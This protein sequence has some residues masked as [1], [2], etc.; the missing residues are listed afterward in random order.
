MSQ[1]TSSAYHLKPQ[2]S[3]EAEP[4]VAGEKTCGFCIFL[5]NKLHEVLE[6]NQTEIDIEQYLLGACA[7]LPT[8]DEANKVGFYTLKKFDQY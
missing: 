3:L 4:N 1:W 5:F 6:Q 7:L 2:D 8:K